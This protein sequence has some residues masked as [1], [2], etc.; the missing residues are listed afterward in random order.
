MLHTSFIHHLEN[1]CSRIENRPVKLRAYEKIYGGDIND[2]Y[3]LAMSETDYFIKINRTDALEMFE[4]EAENLKILLQ[5]RSFVIPKVFKTGIF[6]NNSFLLL[7][8]IEN[9]ETEGN[10][11][12]FAKNLVK[13][14][15][16]NSDYYG[17]DFDNFIGKLPQINTP[18]SN[19]I[20]FYIQNRLQ[21]QITLAGDKIPVH[22]INDFE[23]LYNK[24]PEI[25]SIEKPSLLHGDL[26]NGNYFYNLQG[27]AVLF[28]PAIY[29][30]HR[31][32]DLAMMSLFG[33]FNREIYRIYVE[34]FPLEPDWK[35]RL[36][37]YQLYPLLVHVN[38][39]GS[40]Y[41]SSIRQILKYYI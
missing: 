21:Y 36:K 23:K 26:W 35:N 9:L 1:I 29:F 2:T 38:L 15:K 41:L 33:G 31:E 14:H 30:G 11:A 17:L 20:E 40:G 13:L 8:Y 34:L 6:E 16:N 24:L 37:I 39:F 3:R 5:S 28:D 7:Q 19:W 18:K 10:P 32:V 12:D 25:L 4:K 27:K 22:I